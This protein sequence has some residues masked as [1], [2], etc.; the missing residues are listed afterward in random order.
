MS[1]SPDGATV[2][3]LSERSGL[4]RLMTMAADGSGKRVLVDG[5]AGGGGCA[6]SPDGTT[7][8]FTMFKEQQHLFVTTA[9]GTTI[10]QLTTSGRRNVFP[11]WSPDGRHIA[12]IRY[13][14]LSDKG[15]GFKGDVVLFDV[16]YETHR[17]LPVHVTE[18]NDPARP[19]WRPVTQA[20]RPE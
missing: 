1:W 7:V 4:L 10:R 8:A 16:I 12:Y 11:A 15:P 19:A 13:E 20:T 3:F 6:W 18:L 9:Q 14:T 2:T 17:T 5:Q